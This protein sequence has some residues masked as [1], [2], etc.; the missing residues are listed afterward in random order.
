MP[1]AATILPD[2]ACFQLRRLTAE[3][4][5]ITA[6][7]LTT[8]PSARCP[9]CGEHAV[10]VH[11]RSTRRLADLPW[12]GIA[13][14]LV[15]PVRTF[16]CDHAACARCVCT[17]R[18]P[19]VVAPYARRPLRRAQWFMAVGF[20]AGGAAGARLL[21]ELGAT[22]ALVVA[23]VRA[24]HCVQSATARVLGVDDGAFR[25]RRRY[26]TILVDLERR[27]PVDRLPDRRAAT[28]A[29]GR[30]V[31]PGVEISSRDRGGD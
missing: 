3:A 6:T 1:S 26:G 24:A 16:F 13:L 17:Q 21:R 10:R 23:R 30:K 15:L 28:V 20:A 25:R 14:R 7:V 11:S 9:L 29:R 2:P 8:A 27:R 19:Q 12:H 18:L 31:H 5:T 4:N 22:A